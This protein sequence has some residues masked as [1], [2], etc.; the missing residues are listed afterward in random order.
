MEDKQLVRLAQEGSPE[1]Y[2]ELVTRYQ[3]KVYSMALSF[4]RNRE[5]A[6]DLAQEVFLKAYLA[7]PK[8][9]GKSEF[10]TWLYR[11]S[12]NHIR[13]YLRKKGRAKEVSLDDV[14][15]V[16]FS[17]REQAERA[18]MEKE[19]EARR[20]LVQ[21]FVQGLPEKYRIILTLRDIQ[22]LPYE[23]ISRVLRLSPGTVDSRL[24]R[25]RRMLRVKLAPYMTGEGGAHE[26]S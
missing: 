19:T 13:D 11:I 20:T 1:A 6:D 17:D 12:I 24:H 16:A 26:L 21:K 23:D 10:G 18:E 15:E 9:H 7:L 8:F 22:G 2:E 5:A 4:T 25:A 3:S 14:A